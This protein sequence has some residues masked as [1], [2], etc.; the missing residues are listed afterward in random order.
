MASKKELESGGGAG[1]KSSALYD[2]SAALHCSPD[3]LIALHTA[4]VAG[5]LIRLGGGEKRVKQKL[6]GA[7]MTRDATSDLPVMWLCDLAT[8]RLFLVP[9]WALPGGCGP[10]WLAIGSWPWLAGGLPA[11]ARLGPGR[12]H[13]AALAGWLAAHTAHIHKTHPPPSPQRGELGCVLS[14][15]TPP[16]VADSGDR[17]A[18]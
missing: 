16:L 15:L 2:A 7:Q 18:V 3:C 13:T 8:S 11:K 4:K 1:A 5:S 6:E 17:S 9:G 14:K 12:R 10:A